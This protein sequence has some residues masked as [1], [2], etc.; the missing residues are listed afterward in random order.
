MFNDYGYGGYL[1]WRLYPWK[2]NFIDTRSL[3]ITTMTEYD[4]IMNALPVVEGVNSTASNT[5][6][7]EMLLAHYKINF[8]FIQLFDIYGQLTPLVLKTIESDNWVPIYYD[9]LC[10]VLIKNTAENKPLIERHRVPKEKIYNIIIARASLLALDDE[11]N[12]RYLISLADTFHE[13]GRLDDAIT[14][15]EYALKRM[16]ENTAYQREAGY[17]KI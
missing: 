1:T 9:H 3:N 2:K 14:A 5:P 13:I 7:W 6:L 12:P 8:L 15:C 4:W 10:L 17:V 16:P 11:T